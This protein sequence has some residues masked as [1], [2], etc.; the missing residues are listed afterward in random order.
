ML[1]ESRQ[2][3]PYKLD[4]IGKRPAALCHGDLKRL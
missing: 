1:T 2:H 3:G 4:L